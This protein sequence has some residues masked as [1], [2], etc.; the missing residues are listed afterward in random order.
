M[1]PIDDQ[2]RI[3][4][5]PVG[6][7]VLMPCFVPSMTPLRSTRHDAVVLVER[8]VGEAL[9]AADAGDVQHRVDAAERL[10]RG[11]EHRLDAGLVGHVAAAGHDRVAVLGRGL[12]LPAR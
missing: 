7:I 10:D 11:G 8:D 2:L 4:P 6:S 9:R 3:T 5:P 12:V 1:P